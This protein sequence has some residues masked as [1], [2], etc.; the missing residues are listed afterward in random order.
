VLAA[1][2]PPR[3]PAPAGSSQTVARALDPAGGALP[4]GRDLAVL[5]YWAMAGLAVSLVT[6]RWHPTRNP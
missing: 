4:P 6:F 1:T 2:K 5:A 3:K